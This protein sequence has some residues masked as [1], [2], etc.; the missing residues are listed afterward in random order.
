ERFA[1]LEEPKLR[2]RNFSE[3]YLDAYLE[4]AGERVLESVGAYQL[5]GLGVQLFEAVEGDFFSILGLPLL[6]LLDFL[7]GEKIIIS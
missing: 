2:M 5:E 1:H 3:S 4:Q 6:P 7:R